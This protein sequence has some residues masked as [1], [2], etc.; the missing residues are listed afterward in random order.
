MFILVVL[1]YLH[2]ITTS[3]ILTTKVAGVLCT[4]D[5]LMKMLIKQGVTSKYITFC[6]NRI[7][8]VVS[9]LFLMH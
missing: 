7:Q 1:N 3:I 9:Y 8:S 6:K 5:M 4:L 2:V